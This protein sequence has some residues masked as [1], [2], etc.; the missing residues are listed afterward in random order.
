MF[1]LGGG[2]VAV[3]GVVGAVPV[4]LP[5][6]RGFEEDLVAVRAAGVI[7]EAEVLVQE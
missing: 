1:A 5:G 2:G 6:G 7:A 4:V 3:G